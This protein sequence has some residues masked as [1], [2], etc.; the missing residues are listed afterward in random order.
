MQLF[1]FHVL[2]FSISVLLVSGQVRSRIPTKWQQRT[3]GEGGLTVHITNALEPSYY[4]YFFTAIRNWENAT[5]RGGFNSVKFVIS[6]ATSGGPDCEDGRYN[7]IV[8]CSADYGPTGW[9]GIE[10]TVS[11][12]GDMVKSMVKINNYYLAKVPPDYKQYTLCHELGH[13]LGLEHDDE[14]FYNKGTQSCMDYTAYVKDSQAPNKINYDELTAM[15]GKLPVAAIPQQATSLAKPSAIIL[16]PSGSSISVATPQRILPK[17]LRA[18]PKRVPQRVLPK[19]AP[20]TLKP[21]KQPPRSNSASPLVI[22]NKPSSLPRPTKVTVP[23]STKPTLLPTMRPTPL[24]C[25]SYNNKLCG[26]A[27]Y[28]DF[29][30]FACESQCAGIWLNGK[31]RQQRQESNCKGLYDTP[32][33]ASYECCGNSICQLGAYVGH[34]VCV[35]G[36]PTMSPSQHPSSG[37]TSV[38]SM[39]PLKPT[40][41]PVTTSKPT[42]TSAKASL[43][44]AASS[45]QQQQPEQIVQHLDP[46]HCFC[47]KTCTREV[48]NV[49]TDGS[50]T[51]SSQIDIQMKQYALSELYACVLVSQAYAACGD[52]KCNPYLCPGSELHRRMQG[53]HSRF[54][55]REQAQITLDPR[56]FVSDLGHDPN[57]LGELI[58]A[59]ATSLRYALHK[60]NTIGNNTE[61][62]ALNTNVRFSFMPD[63]VFAYLK[64]LGSKS[65]NHN[66]NKEN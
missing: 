62:A 10:Q 49:M 60:T 47:P 35:P 25:C 42:T 14:N 4:S 16:R 61:A 13:S 17:P 41:A 38:P 50:Q 53:E 9:V 56:N 23:P 63:D 36:P 44:A 54:I 64:S 5:Q 27:G 40:M 46:M 33:V 1:V 65:A 66:S 52:T 11:D 51:C 32:C 37:P 28:C 43:A 57:R 39:A 45:Q 59:T 58:D 24:P 15:Y 22:S 30:K 12:G 7:G 31:T 6:T 48:L 20:T 21:I 18:A 19:P 34:A 8:I 55:Q 29:S 2:I 26:M 3:P